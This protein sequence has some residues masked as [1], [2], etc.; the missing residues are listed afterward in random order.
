MDLPPLGV[1]PSA[2]LSRDPPA[3]VS[4][5]ILHHKSGPV[6]VEL[7][8]QDAPFVSPV[9]HVAVGTTC[10]LVILT[11]LPETNDPVVV[12]AVYEWY[13]RWT[14]VAEL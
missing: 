9:T 10:V 11:F 12:L 8:G 4:I 13:M 3:V 14:L 1:T 2:R 5:P 7:V 6:S